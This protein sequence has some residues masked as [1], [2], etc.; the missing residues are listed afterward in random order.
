MKT[1]HLLQPDPSISKKDGT[2][3]VQELP[4]PERN[5]SSESKMN[6]PTLTTLAFLG[7]SAL[8]FLAYRLIQ[9]AAPK[10]ILVERRRIRYRRRL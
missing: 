1:T 3:V 4:R 8:A 10:P 5:H 7:L 2:R 9:L 6:I